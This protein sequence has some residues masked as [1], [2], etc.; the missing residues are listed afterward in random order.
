[1]HVGQ[2]GKAWKKVNNNDNK[3]W[4][5]K[6]GGERETNQYEIFIGPSAESSDCPNGKILTGSEITFTFSDDKT[7]KVYAEPDGSQYETR[8]DGQEN[9]DVVLNTDERTI[10]YEKTGVGG[11]P[12]YIKAINVGGTGGTTC[13]YGNRDTNLK[14]VILEPY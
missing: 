3:K 9:L 6:D 4:R 7:F 1:M 5:I 11:A 10:R 14:T 12:G 8:I 2:K 13:N